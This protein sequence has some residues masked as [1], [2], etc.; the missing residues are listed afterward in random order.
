MYAFLYIIYIKKK[1]KVYLYIHIFYM[2]QTSWELDKRGKLYLNCI[3]NKKGKKI[4]RKAKLNEI[5]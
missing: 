3:I 5:K 1:K 2:K 4:K